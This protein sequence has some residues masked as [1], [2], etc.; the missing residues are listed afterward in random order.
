MPRLARLDAPGVLHHVII[1]GIERRNIFED[2]KDRDNLLKRLGEL[3]PAT[4]TSC[5]AW[6][7]LSNHAHFLL[8]TGTTGLS[9]VIKRLLTGYVVSFNRRYLRHGPLFQNRFKS[10]VCQEDIYLKE[11]VRYIHLNPLRAGIVSDLNGLSAYGYCGHAALM[12][13]RA[14]DWMD[15]KYVLSCFGK[16]VSTARRQYN[17]YVKEGLELGNRPE[18]V[19]GG[20]IRSLGGWEAVKKMRIDGKERVKGDQRILGDSEFVFDVLK[21]A[22]EKFERYYEMKRL[23]YDLNTIE[24]RVC[25]IYK[26][27]KEDIFS[28]SREKVK[29]DARAL[30]C[31][32]AHR[33]LG[34]GQRELARRL[35]MTQPGVGYAVIKG[36]AIS[37]S[38]SYRIKN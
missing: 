29:S 8:R 14:C 12:G 9:I 5:Y 38:N 28:R 4:K 2:N 26:I 15:T 32:W 37:K 11:L 31:F 35:G 20:L 23:G 19:G 30:F 22:N 33:E 24:D 27:E 10:I 16:T 13:K 34:Y 7:M 25:E 21:E 3:L 1:R 36:E 18:L 17:S 6:A